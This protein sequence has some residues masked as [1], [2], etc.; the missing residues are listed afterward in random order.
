MVRSEQPADGPQA[1]QLSEIERHSPTHYVVAGMGPRDVAHRNLARIA[2]NPRVGKPRC[3][4]QLIRW[5]DDADDDVWRELESA[6]FGRGRHSR[7][8]IVRTHPL[9]QRAIP[10]IRVEVRRLDGLPIGRPGVIPLAVHLDRVKV[11][12][13][14][15]RVG[16][17][18]ALS[19]CQ[20]LCL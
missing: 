16:F 11:R 7:E 8:G 20:H 17:S 14:Q 19:E 10:D 1:P 3:Q 15:H 9:H 6:T 2:G 12:A 5:G 13:G 4:G 18:L